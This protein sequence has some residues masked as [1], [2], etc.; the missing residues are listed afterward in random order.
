MIFGSGITTGSRLEDI[1]NWPEDI[2]KVT[3]RGSKAAAQKYL[4]TKKPWVRTPVTG[5]LL[6]AARET[7]AKGQP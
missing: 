3:S 1:E 5:I 4:D 6:P 2:G 7:A